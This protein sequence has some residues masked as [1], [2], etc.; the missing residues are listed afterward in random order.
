MTYTGKIIARV[1]YKGIRGYMINIFDDKSRVS[2]LDFKKEFDFKKDQTV[3]FWG[4]GLGRVESKGLFGKD[5]G[6]FALKAKY[7]EEV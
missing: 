2:V 7:M 3:T 5:V 1:D 4:Y 6:V